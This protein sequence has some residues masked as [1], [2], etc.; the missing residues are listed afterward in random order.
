MTAAS[1]QPLPL[2]LEFATV[3]DAPELTRLWYNAF[4]TPALLAIWPD[5]PGVRQWWEETM[6]HDM[7]H[8]PRERYLKVVDPQSGRIAAFAKWS[9]QSAEERGPRWPAWHPDMD[10]ARCDAFLQNLEAN[11]ARLVGDARRNFYL[12]MLAT[13][14]DFRRRGAARLLLEWGCQE[15]DQANVPAY[16]DASDEGRVVYELYG[17]VALATQ[18]GIASMVREPRPKEV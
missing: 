10:P 15:A 5:T 16:I 9:L 7:Q 17:F 6:R 11:R 3:E 8:Q 2:R 12:D 13:H 14:T 18:P 4:N 1:A